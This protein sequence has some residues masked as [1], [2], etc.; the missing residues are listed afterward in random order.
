[1]VRGFISAVILIIFSPQITV[2]VLETTKVTTVTHEKARKLIY[3]N[4]FFIFRGCP[5]RQVTPLTHVTA[6]ILK[7]QFLFSI[8][9]L[10]LETTNVTI[11]YNAC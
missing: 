3:L 10:S 9:A 6:E 8:Q 2:F 1:M 7:C 4:V 5:W 11:L